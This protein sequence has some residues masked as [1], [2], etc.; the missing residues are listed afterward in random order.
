MTAPIQYEQ[1]DFE[2]E[3][4]T[5]VEWRRGVDGGGWT[6]GDVIGV[7]LVSVAAGVCVL[8]FIVLFCVLAAIG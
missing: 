7:A 4:Q 3:H 1:T 6:V 2:S 5:L 8:V